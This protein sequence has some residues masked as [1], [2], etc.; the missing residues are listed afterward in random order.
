MGAGRKKRQ[1][2]IRGRCSRCGEQSTNPAAAAKPGVLRCISG[3][4]PGGDF[5]APCGAGEPEQ[6]RGHGSSENLPP[7]HL[8]SCAGIPVP[9]AGRAVPHIHLQTKGAVVGSGERSPSQQCDSSWGL[10]SHNAGQE[11][12]ELGGFIRCPDLQTAR[13]D[14]IRVFTEKQPPH[15]PLPPCHG[16]QHTMP[17]EELKTEVSTTPLQRAPP[18]R[19]PI[20]WGFPEP[21]ASSLCSPQPAVDFLF[22]NLLNCFLIPDKLFT[23]PRHPPPQRPAA[24]KC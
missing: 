11:V 4:H 6:D 23:P 1:H 7:A 13:N 18:L 5:P 22:R 15:S 12:E 17:W 14:V 3:A 8:L 2:R 10:G 16:D 24:P 21:E 20:A 9:W 19:L